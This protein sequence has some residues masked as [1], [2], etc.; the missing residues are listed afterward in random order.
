MWACGARLAVAQEAQAY[1]K[2]LYGEFGLVITSAHY[3]H[4][5]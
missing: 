3:A 2:S 5:V 4:K 1:Y